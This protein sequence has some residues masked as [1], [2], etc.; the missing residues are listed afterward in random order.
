[1]IASGDAT[2]LGSAATVAAAV[3][4]ADACAPTLGAVNRTN[5]TRKAKLG[6]MIR[7]VARI[8]VRHALH[9][10]VEFRQQNYSGL[11]IGGG[12]GNERPTCGPRSIDH[13]VR[14]VRRDV[15]V[16]SRTRPHE[17]A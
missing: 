9:E 13:Q 2:S 10:R 14:H 12:M 6:F 4:L 3:A 15:H 16:L 17:L 11:I 8:D 7:S 1:M 5:D